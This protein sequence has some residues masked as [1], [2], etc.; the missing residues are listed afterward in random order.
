MRGFKKGFLLVVACVCLSACQSQNNKQNNK[1]PDLELIAFYET[2]SQ[3]ANAN[4]ANAKRRHLIADDV[5]DDEQKPIVEKG[6]NDNLELKAQVRNTKRLSFVDIVLFCEGTETSY[7]FNEGHGKYQCSSTTALLNGEWVTDISFSVSADL[8]HKDNGKCANDTYV[9]IQEISFLDLSGDYAKPNLVDSDIKKVSVFAE[10]DTS[11]NPHTWSEWDYPEGKKQYEP[12]IRTRECSVC[13]HKEEET[14]SP[15]CMEQASTFEAEYSPA[16]DSQNRLSIFVL[17]SKQESAYSTRTVAVDYGVE[18]NKY[19]PDILTLTFDIE[20]DTECDVAALSVSFFIN[21]TGVYSPEIISDEEFVVTLNN[22]PIK[23]GSLT[24][25]TRY[26]SMWE[27][28]CSDFLLGYHLHLNQGKNTIKMYTT[29][30]SNILVVDNI[31]IGSS[32][33]LT[34][35][36]AVPSNISK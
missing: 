31:K 19:S 36:T 21:K 27:N 2:S 30:Y 32:G 8:Y 18:L 29:Y 12:Y 13:Q 24:V 22:T 35:P 1:Q 10:N 7:V 5:Q 14:L 15:D 20:S 17:K 16:I 34:W 9:E 11:T 23:F 25:P 6:S 33:N 28:G 4:K 3:N 26:F